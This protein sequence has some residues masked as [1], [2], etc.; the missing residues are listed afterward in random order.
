M[1][2]KEKYKQAL[3]IA[4]ECLQDGT[5]TTIA[6]D[7][8]LEIFPELKEK[9]S[10]DE[11]IKSIIKGC[12]YASD[13]TPEG[14]EEIFAWL[15]KQGEFNDNIITR[16]DEILQAISIGLTNVVENA[17]WSDFGGIPIEEI[18]DWLE[19]QGEGEGDKEKNVILPDVYDD[20]RIRNS[21]ALVL[22]D[23]D[24][25]VLFNRGVTLRAALN[26]LEKQGEKKSDDE[27]MK[28]R[29]KAY[30]DGYKHGQDNI[31][32]FLGKESIEALEH[33]VR[34]IGESGY[35][36]PYDNRTKLVY[37]LLEQLKQIVK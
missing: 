4:K 29:R 10:E 25:S 16:N 15:E 2:Y 8:I 12:V 20:E 27:V 28:I 6:R 32:I 23:V 34:S 7:Y 33:F 22:T 24:E 30:S 21:I 9:E 17:G 18:Q 5:I 35:A 36:S 3:E 14:R 13:I 26:W 37:R 19:K 1:N 11:R 31:A